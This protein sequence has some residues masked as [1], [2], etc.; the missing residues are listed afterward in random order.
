MLFFS[1]ASSIARSQSS[2]FFLSRIQIFLSPRQRTSLLTITNSGETSIDFEVSI[3]Q[4]QQSKDGKDELSPAEGIVVFPLVLSVPPGENRNIRIGTRQPPQ[5]VES[6]YRLFITELP[7]PDIQQP[8][9]PGSQIRI[10]KRFSLPV[11]VA[12]IEPV[13]TAEIVDSRIQNGQLGFTIR[14]T[15]NVHV[16][17]S[18]IVLTGQTADEQIYFENSLDSV[19]ILAGRERS[20]S[21]VALPQAGCEQVRQVTIRLDNR[22]H[23]LSTQIPTPNGICR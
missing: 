17:T 13:L 7:S 6:T 18:V 11:F 15:G 3:E 5:I 22:R 9:S 14:N 12:P 19:Y 8:T 20:F 23:P 16:Q 21:Q 1:V 10:L 4:W 2:N